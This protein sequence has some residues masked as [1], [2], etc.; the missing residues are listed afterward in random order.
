L[1]VERGGENTG[2]NL[3]GLVDCRGHAR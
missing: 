1:V 2:I 3:S